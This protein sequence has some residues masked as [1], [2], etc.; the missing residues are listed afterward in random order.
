M[1][2][3]RPLMK[4]KVHLYVTQVSETLTWL[5]LHFDPKTTFGNTDFPPNAATGCG[6]A[7]Q[8]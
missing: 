3:D 8:C 4:D 6:P 7:G 5:F 2:I 1:S